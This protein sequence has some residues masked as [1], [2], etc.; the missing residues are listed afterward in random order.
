MTTLPGDSC[1]PWNMNRLRGRLT[2]SRQ[3]PVTNAE[4]TD[5]LSGVLR[6]PAK[7]P[8]P[9]FALKMML[10]EMA[11]ELLLA[12]MRVIPEKLHKAGFTFENTD[13]TASPHGVTARSGGF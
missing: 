6:R 1:L 8:V 12:S 11:D 5:V 9:V 10:G 13:L 4:F 3:Q 2:W 7:M